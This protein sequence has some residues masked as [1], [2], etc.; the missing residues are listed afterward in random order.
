MKYVLVMF[1]VLFVI[2]QQKVLDWE[3]YEGEKASIF[4]YLRQAEVELDKPLET[5]VQES[6]QKEIDSVKV[7]TVQNGV[8]S[9]PSF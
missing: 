4:N 7:C 6:A 2:L 8:L 5:L 3:L 1:T 9:F